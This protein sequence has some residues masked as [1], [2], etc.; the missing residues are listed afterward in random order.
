MGSAWYCS[1]LSLYPLNPGLLSHFTG[2]A[3]QYRTP[4][5]TALPGSG[6]GPDVAGRDFRESSAGAQRA[7]DRR[8]S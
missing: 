6:P 8:L 5:T 7:A 1:S 4:P 2:R 3:R